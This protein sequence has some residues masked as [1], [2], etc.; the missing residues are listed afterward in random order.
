ML[1]HIERFNYICSPHGYIFIYYC[2]IFISI[3]LNQK[4]SNE[5]GITGEIELT[6]KIT[7]I[8]G[9]ISKL[10]GAKLAGIKKVLISEENTDDIEEIKTKYSEIVDNIE[11]ITVKNIIDCQLIFL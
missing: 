5:I 10:Q 6:G 1:F 3:L 9:L 11:I 8:G 4:I 2:S 7:K